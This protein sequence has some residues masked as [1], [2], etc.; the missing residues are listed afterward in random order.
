M[1]IS[2]PPKDDI[3]IGWFNID[4]ESID[5]YNLKHKSYSIGLLGHYNLNESTSL[6]LR[7]GYSRIDI[8][9]YSY[10]D[11]LGV[12]FDESNHGI[13]NK[14]HIAPG[15]YW[16]VKFNKFGLYGGFEIPYNFHGKFVAEYRFIQTDLSTNTIISEDYSTQELPEG[17]SVG[18]GALFG[19]E[20][21]PASWFSLGAEFSP[22]LLY[23]RLSG[24][25][26]WS[27]QNGNTWNT[28]DENK[29]LGF[30]DQR[31]SINLNIWF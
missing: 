2:T 21:T 26:V 1:Q 5:G 22:S 31:F 12:N 23:A 16:P 19:F 4:G 9:E 6:R 18:V 27:D 10:Q 28:Q 25:T 8:L 15:I 3:S 20:F 24:E 11:I 17:Y 14:I 13:Q 7:F 30:Y 29:G